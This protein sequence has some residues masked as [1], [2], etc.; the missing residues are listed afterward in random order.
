MAKTW[1][2]TIKPFLAKYKKDTD[3]VFAAYNKEVKKL[4]LTANNDLNNLWNKKYKSKMD[5]LEDWHDKEYRKIWNE[6]HKK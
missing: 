1:K 2:E 3:K 4:K 5:K 6:F